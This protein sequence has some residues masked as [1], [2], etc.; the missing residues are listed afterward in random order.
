M[1]ITQKSTCGY[2]Y[3]RKSFDPRREYVFFE[4]RCY[5]SDDSP[6]YLEHKEYGVTIAHTSS[7]VHLSSDIPDKCWPVICG[8]D[9]TTA[10]MSLEIPHID[11]VSYTYI[12]WSGIGYC[13]GDDVTYKRLNIAEL[14]KDCETYYKEMKGIINCEKLRTIYARYKTTVFGAKVV[15]PKDDLWTDETDDT[16][17]ILVNTNE[18]VLFEAFLM[19]M[20]EVLQ[21]NRVDDAMSV[22]IDCIF[23]LVF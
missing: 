20:V 6:R 23:P 22:T 7:T 12:A 13:E 1:S 14:K 15:P 9:I 18:L 10:S 5:N 3:T 2:T 21:I 16:E 17:A 8:W 19:I 11:D 4:L